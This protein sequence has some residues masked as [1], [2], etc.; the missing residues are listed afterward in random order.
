MSLM[1]THYLLSSD[2]YHAFCKC[3]RLGQDGHIFESKVT[4]Y[5]AWLVFVDP[6]LGPPL[7]SSAFAISKYNCNKS[8]AHQTQVHT[9]ELHV[10][11]CQ[12][13]AGDAVTVP[14]YSD[15][16]FQSYSQSALGSVRKQNKH[17]HSQVS[18]PCVTPKRRATP[19]LLGLRHTLLSAPSRI[20]V[21]SN[22]YWPPRRNRKG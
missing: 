14:T 16:T 18:V 12:R 20:P 8:S 15:N 7:L 1:E 10:R 6:W 5:R 21:C 17:S 22:D 3:L 11:S 13:L 2:L 19:T 4:S 9:M